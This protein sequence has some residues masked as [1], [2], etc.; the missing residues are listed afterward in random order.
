MAGLHGRNQWR[1]PVLLAGML[2]A[3]GR[4]VPLAAALG[5]PCLWRPHPEHW[6]AKTL[7]SGS[8]YPAFDEGRH[9]TRTL[10]RP[11]A[12]YLASASRW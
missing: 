4:R 5:R 9:D 8:R 10:T 7:A 2:F 11:G 3:Q 6:R 12:P 1:L